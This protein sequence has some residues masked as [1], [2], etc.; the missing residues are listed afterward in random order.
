MQHKFAAEYILI[1][2]KSADENLTVKI[3]IY[4]YILLHWLLVLKAI[5]RESRGAA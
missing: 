3:L 5:R 2:N 1:S 4:F